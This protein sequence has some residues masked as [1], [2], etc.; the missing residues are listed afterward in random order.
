MISFEIADVT[1]PFIF[2]LPSRMSSQISVLK[3]WL[4]EVTLNCGF[5]AGRS[6]ETFQLVRNKKPVEKK[7]IYFTSNTL[8]LKHRK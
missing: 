6:R 2:N 1:I 8:Y 4:T 7:N 5:Y 3:K